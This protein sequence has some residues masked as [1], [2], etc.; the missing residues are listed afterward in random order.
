MIEFD[1]QVGQTYET[2]DGMIVEIVC[3]LPKKLA[4]GALFLAMEQVETPE[5]IYPLTEFGLA[6]GRFDGFHPHSLFKK[7]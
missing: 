1:V 5:R 2:R 7:V 4:N 6:P 3:K